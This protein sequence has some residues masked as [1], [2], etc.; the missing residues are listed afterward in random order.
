MVLCTCIEHIINKI[1]LDRD[2]LSQLSKL[3][4][5]TFLS[6]CYIYIV[7]IWIGIYIVNM[8]NVYKKTG[9]FVLWVLLILFG[10]T[11]YH[12]VMWVCI[13]I[14]LTTK[15]FDV[16]ITLITFC[17]PRKKT[18]TIVGSYKSVEPERMSIVYIK[19]IQ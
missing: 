3:H 18:A 11:Q 19:F 12:R 9:H 1:L 13:C 15:Y 2:K 4:L 6:I 8:F 14:V 10:N 16:Y 17:D 5:Q 7:V